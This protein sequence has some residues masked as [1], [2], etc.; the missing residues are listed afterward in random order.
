M[1]EGF[2]AWE[3]QVQSERVR[4]AWGGGGWTQMKDEVGGGVSVATA[5][6]LG[7]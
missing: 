1:E 5:P 2:Q 6:A 3:G 4:Q 7:S